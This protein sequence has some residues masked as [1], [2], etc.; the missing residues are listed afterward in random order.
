MITPEIVNIARDIPRGPRRGAISAEVYQ[1]EEIKNFSRMVRLLLYNTYLNLYSIIISGHS[2]RLQ[3][4]AS[5]PE[6][7]RKYKI[8]EVM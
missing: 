5:P 7:L 6:G 8:I 2:K 4:N 1:D 3:N